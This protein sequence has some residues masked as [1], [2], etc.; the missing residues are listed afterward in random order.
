MCRRV[1][2]CFWALLT[3]WSLCSCDNDIF[4]AGSDVLSEDDQI[5]VRVDTFAI[6]SNIISCSSVLSRPDSF[7]LGEIETDFG[8]LRA[9]ILTQL[10]CPEG[11][12]F[13]ENAV[14][15]SACLFLYY[16]SWM[17]DGNTPIAINVY[18]MDKQGL[19]Y[20]PITP[21]STDEDIDKFCSLSDASCLLRN[22]RIV[23]A[24]EMTDSIYNSYSDSYYPMVRFR[25]NDQFLKRFSQ[26]SHYSSQDAFN[27]FFKGLYIT[28]SFGSST[29]LSISDISLGVY[30]HFNY[31]QLGASADTTVNDMKAYYANAE[32]R[33]LNRVVYPQK[34]QLM[35]R[36]EAEGDLYNYVIAPAGVYTRMSIPMH[37]IQDSI[38]SGL[39][40]KKRPYINMAQLKVDVV[41]SLPSSITNRNDWIQPAPYMLLIKESS[42]QRFFEERE[43]PSDTVAIL[44][45][46]SSSTDNF[47]VTSYFY[48]YNLA[49]LITDQVRH[50]SLPDV[51]DMCLVPVSVESPEGSSGITTSITSVQE[52]QT[53]SATVIR[54]AK[55]EDNPLTLEVLYSGFGGPDG[56]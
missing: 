24:S 21:Y 43:L 14:F 45:S 17:G 13:P 47:G 46:L 44:A 2:F 22:H 40:H 56:L 18:E 50:S 53:I 39:K 16:R 38:L 48:T 6:Q 55:N 49:Q 41:Y 4:S 26:L 52:S 19:E 10:A 11:F 15:D 12:A 8:T 25:L 30:Y 32:V 36:L 31:R 7:L 9:D 20:S 37:A 51:L 3:A 5:I 35:Q 27:E 42:M 29:V 33:T 28:T 54:S 34:E 23:A 1:V